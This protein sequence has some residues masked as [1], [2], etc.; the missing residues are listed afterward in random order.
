MIYLVDSGVNN[1]IIKCNS[2]F[3]PNNNVNDKVGHGTSM[4]SIIKSVDINADIFS[5]KL[6]DENPTLDD[7][8]TC[9]HYLN[10]LDIQSSD[11]I[12]FNANFKYTLYLT[13]FENLLYCLS[14]KCVIIVPAGNNSD[15]IDNWSP[16]RCDFVY[17]V[18]SLNKSR[19]KTKATNVDGKI[20]KVDFYIVSTNVGALNLS[21]N[22]IRVFGTSAGAA[23]LAAL[24]HKIRSQDKNMLDILVDTY[25]DEAGFNTRNNQSS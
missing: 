18:G 7:A 24:M 14:K 23:I 10:S 22:A 25:N 16:A 5:I 8:I 11:V 4:A 19:I 3:S 6:G 20:K 2:H 15:S 12:L 13:Q 21:G 17:T 9:L 1:S